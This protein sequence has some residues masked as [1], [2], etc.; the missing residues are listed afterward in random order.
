[1]HE[2]LSLHVLELIIYVILNI[3]NDITCMFHNFVNDGKCSTPGKEGNEGRR[4]DH[5]LGGAVSLYRIILTDAIMST[6]KLTHTMTLGRCHVDLHD[7]VPIQ[8]GYS[9]CS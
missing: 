5:W 6:D 8:S 4:M 7:T 3:L 9:C 2:Q 1:M